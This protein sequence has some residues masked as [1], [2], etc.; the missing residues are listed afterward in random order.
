MADAHPKGERDIQRSRILA[1]IKRENLEKLL[2][3]AQRLAQLEMLVGREIPRGPVETAGDQGE[4]SV[5][6]A[7]RVTP[8]E[9][10]PAAEQGQGSHGK[11]E[12]Q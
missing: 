7:E 6:D 10:S 1:E 5:G 4:E 9:G 8:E 12:G 2:R 11:H 3:E